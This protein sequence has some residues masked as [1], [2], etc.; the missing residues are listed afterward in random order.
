MTPTECFPFFGNPV[1]STIHAEIAPCVAMR[2]TTCPRTLAITASSDH[3][4][5]PTKCKSDWCCAAVRSGA[6]IAA[7]GSTLLR[8]AGIIR[9]V[10]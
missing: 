9:P 3:S 2:G 4:P 10:Q 7:S 1:S 6:V 5:L 8:P